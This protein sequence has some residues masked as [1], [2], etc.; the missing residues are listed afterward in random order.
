MKVSSTDTERVIEA[1][2][3]QNVNEQKKQQAGNQGIGR[4]GSNSG[5][6]T[7]RIENGGKTQELFS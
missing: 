1:G 4:S 6:S 7:C 2:G 3:H 5:S